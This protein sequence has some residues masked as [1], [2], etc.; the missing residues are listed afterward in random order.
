MTFDTACSSSL[1]ALAYAASALRH[2]SAGAALAGGANLPMDW[3]TSAMFVSAGARAHASRQS[4]L[5]RW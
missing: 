1:V 2:D 3:E 4:W 5:H